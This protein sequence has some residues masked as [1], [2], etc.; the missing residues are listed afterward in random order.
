M[1]SLSSRVLAAIRQVGTEAVLLTDDQPVFPVSI[2]P[3]LR[4]QHQE[5][6][7]LGVGRNR[8][9][10]LYAPASSAADRLE[11]GCLLRSKGCLY[12]VLQR[13]TVRFGGQALYIWAMLEPL[14]EGDE[15]PSN[16]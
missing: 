3:G 1:S 9:A 12:R 8:Q 2:Q 6:S 11:E 10:R 15:T 16:S 14:E 4:L 7:P 5:D 13:E